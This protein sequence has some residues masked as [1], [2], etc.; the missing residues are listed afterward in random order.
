[1]NSALI[2]SSQKAI[3]QLTDVVKPLG[4][5]K[6]VAASSG[7]EARRIILDYDFDMV[8]INSPLSD[9]FGH[10]LGLAV[11]ANSGAGVIIIVRN[12]VSDEVSHRVEEGGVFVITK[13]INKP[14]FYQAVRLLN[15]SRIRVMGLRRENMKLQTK[16][17]DLRVIDRAKCVLIQYLNMTEK[18]A[19]RYI[20]KQAMDMRMSKK[21]IADKIISTYDK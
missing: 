4:F 21:E 17:E 20:E 10:E 14:M 6:I 16:I 7:T 2:V 1:M 5:E 9:E 13:P 18:Q 3:V 19:H 11:A 15:A 8:F 12:E